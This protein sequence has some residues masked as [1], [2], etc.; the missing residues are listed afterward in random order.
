MRWKLEMSDLNV[1]NSLRARRRSVY[2]D[3]LVIVPVRSSTE[4]CRNF[5]YPFSKIAGSW[6][7][8]GAARELCPESGLRGYPALVHQR[9]HLRAV[10]SLR[11]RSSKGE[12][13][14]LAQEE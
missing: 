5:R 8:E 3:G 11:Y 4:E 13:W 14:L 7:N 9:Q 12:R 6:D 2:C 10:F 1:I